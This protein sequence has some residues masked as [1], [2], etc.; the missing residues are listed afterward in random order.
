MSDINVS[1]EKQSGGITAGQ[2][3]INGG[4]GGSLE[5]GVLEKW[6][7]GKGVY[8]LDHG[9]VK[10]IDW[11]GTD[12][13]IVEAAR[14][15]TGKGFLGWEPGVCPICNADGR[16]CFACEGKGKIAGDKNLLETLY[17]MAHATPFEMCELVVETQA[18]IAVYREHHRH[19]TQSYNEMS[20]RYMPLPDLNYV[21]T[22]ERLLIG[23]GH[24]TKQAG[25]VKDAEPLTRETAEHYRQWLMDEY[26]SQEQLYQTALRKGVPKELARMHIG[27][28]RYSRMRA[29]ANLRN[30]L[31]FETLR[32][33]PAAQWEI[34]QYATVIANIIATLWPRTWKLYEEYT[35][36]AVRFSGTE[37]S[38]L[39]A[40][41]GS[42]WTQREGVQIHYTALKDELMALGLDDRRAKKMIDKLTVGG[43]R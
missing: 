31:S 20:A 35:L 16:V 37:I 14:M 25:T 18:P 12:E 38:A 27:V 28:G 8:V 22:V 43:V 1:S 4:I 5:G 21:P 9:Y 17:E 40:I 36:Q 23:G 3:I 11:M 13:N 19:R 15:S 42:Q 2:V 32:Y 39:R 29:K 7:K 33:H 24:L 10:L 34:R 6:E 41:I 26:A 30:W